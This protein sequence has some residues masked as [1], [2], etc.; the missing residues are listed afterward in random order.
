MKRPTGVLVDTNILSYLLRRSPLGMHYER[1]RAGRLAFVACTT[2]EE[3]YFGAEK[4]K[5]GAAK[6]RELEALIAEYGVLP[7]DLD[8]AKISARVSRRAGARGTGTRDS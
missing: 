2:P 3:L 1:L 7:G 5:W 8:I 6:R 4:K